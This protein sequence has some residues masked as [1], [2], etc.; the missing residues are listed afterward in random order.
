MHHSKS[1]LLVGTLSAAAVAKPVDIQGRSTFKVHQ[2]AVPKTSRL[3]SAQMLVQAYS[4][5]NISV[6]QDLKQAASVQ[7]GQV[8]NQPESGDEVC[9]PS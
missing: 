4:K 1:L 9:R 7:S 5:Y 2:V 8:T 6:P 3:S